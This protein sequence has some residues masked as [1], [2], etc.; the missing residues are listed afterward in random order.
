MSRAVLLE[1]EGREYDHVP[2]SADWYWVLGIIAA[3]IAIAAI[4]FGNY[5]LALLVIIA[6]ATIA[7]HA[8]KEPP[9][10][11]FGLV[12]KGLMIGE[13]LHPF[14]HMISFSILEDPEGELPPLLSIKNETWF[15]PHLVIPLADVDAEAVYIHFAQHVDER[16]HTH[17]LS[18]LVAALLGF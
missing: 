4:L 18:D 7:L 17:S 13:D 9:I 8:A 5:L 15:S 14:E 16:E 3:A 10:H 12:D 2:K 11:R 6:A 1:W